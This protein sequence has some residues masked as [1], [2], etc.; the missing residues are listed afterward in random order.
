MEPRL[1][2]VH[3][4]QAWYAYG[5]I[6]GVRIVRDV[7]KDESLPHAHVAI[8]DALADHVRE[9]LGDDRGGECPGREGKA[10][11]ILVDHVAFRPDF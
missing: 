5:V 4:V 8:L 3:Y 11:T 6:D 7:K 9:E 10:P 1:I 2:V